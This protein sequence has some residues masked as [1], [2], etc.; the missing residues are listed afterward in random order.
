MD[1][2]AR[3]KQIEQEIKQTPYHKGT[4]HHIGKLRAR[5][6]KLK[7]ERLFGA[8]RRSGGRVGF[9]LK[10][11]GDATVVLVGPPSVG[12][13][14]L[15]N[16]LTQAQSKVADYDFT[17]LSVVP[18]IMDYHGAKILIFDL[19]G[20]IKDA[21]LG[22]GQG[23]QVLSVVRG[24]D[25]VL[26]MLDFNRTNL[27]EI[28]KELY[29]IGI[30][31]DEL[32]PKINIKKTNSGGLKISHTTS[33]SQVSLPTIKELANEFRIR[34]GEL[35]IKE[36]IT[37]TRLIDGLMGNRKYL[38]YLVVVNKI[39]LQKKNPPTIPKA[40]YISAKE[41]SGLEPLRVAIWEKLN[42]MK[43]YLKPLGSKADINQPL[44]VKK[45][46]SLKD[47]LTKIYLA[48]KE[49]FTRARIYGPG[50]KFP[51]QEVNLNFQPIEGTIISFLRG[52]G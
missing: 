1:V 25:L 50:A 29:A 48:D 31:L 21:A 9:A 51:G 24:A 37:L 38:P 52:S 33:L 13:S 11:S 42:M 17:T 47:I 45:D 8:S 20:I 4:E 3:I 30:R 28:K 15:L 36:D 40:V 27:Q 2:E 26:I 6:A 19:P 18:G 46:S 43:V 22:K 44:I 23:R 34:N 35:I 10:K 16:A 14:S 5:L 12:K 32:P 39:D 49:N 7:D 41:K